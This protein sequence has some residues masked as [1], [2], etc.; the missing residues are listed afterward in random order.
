M[1]DEPMNASTSTSTAQNATTRREFIKT[2]GK[3]AAGAAL[4]SAIAARSYA[5]ESNTIKIALIGCGGRGT[6]AAAQALS[7]QGPTQLYAVADFFE[8]RLQGSLNN[9]KQRFSS[10]MD[11]PPDRQ[12]V[13]LDAY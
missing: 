12:F 11:V 1:I 10:K 6:G 5:A 2:S 3:A 4:A 13:G 7:T 8:N 9:L